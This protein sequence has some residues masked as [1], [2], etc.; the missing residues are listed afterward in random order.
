M[1]PG[2]ATAIG[3]VAGREVVHRPV[4][5]EEHAEILRA[6]GLDDGL[7][8]FV[9]SVD[10]GIATGDLD[11]DDAALATLI[12]RPTTPFVDALRAAV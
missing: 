3:E 10:A 7:I 6:A 5:A 2:V 9:T 11:S 8:G 1:S 12:G 4:T